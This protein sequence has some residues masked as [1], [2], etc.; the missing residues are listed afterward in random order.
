MS[1]SEDKLKV[2]LRMSSGDHPQID[3]ESER[4]KQ[5]PEDMLRAY[6]FERQTD[7]D[8]YLPLVDFAYNNRPHKVIGMSPFEMNYGMNSNAPSTIG[9]PK[10]CHS[11][12]EF[13]ANLE[14]NLEIAKAKMKQGADRAKEYVDRKRSL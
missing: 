5:I 14:A 6:V 9:M 13:L 1:D 11:A 3:G 2:S 12:S 7:W 10:K 8:S 4:V